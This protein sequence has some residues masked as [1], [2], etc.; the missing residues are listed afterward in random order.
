MGNKKTKKQGG[1][2][3]KRDA[4]HDIMKGHRLQYQTIYYK[5]EAKKLDKRGIVSSWDTTRSN[6][7]LLN[8]SVQQ[9]LGVS[10]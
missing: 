8:R 2:F 4:V 10:N 1:V 7:I 3:S 5:R 6:I 9:L